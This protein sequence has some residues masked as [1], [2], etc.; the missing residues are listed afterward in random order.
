MVEAISAINSAAASGDTAAT[1]AALKA[2]AASVRSVTE[3]CAESYTEKLAAA[4]QHK[5]DSGKKDGK[6]H[7]CS[8]YLRSLRFGY[9]LSSLFYVNPLCT[10][11]EDSEGWSEHRIREGANY[12]HNSRTGSSQWERPAE[13]KGQSTELNRDEIQVRKSV[14]VAI[15]V[16]VWFLIRT[17]WDQY[18]FRFSE[19]CTATYAHNLCTYRGIVTLYCPWFLVVQA[20]VTHFESA[21]T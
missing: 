15:S 13:F 20:A 11:V 5:V 3:E 6:V 7:I 9:A 19:N 12:Y 1:M 4:R 14:Y 21:A 2:P 8:L 16:W 17:A 10:G 18:P